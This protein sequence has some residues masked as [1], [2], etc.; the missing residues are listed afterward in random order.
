MRMIIVVMVGMLTWGIVPVSRVLAQGKPKLDLKGKWNLVDRKTNETIATIRLTPDPQPARAGIEEGRY[1]SMTRW[2]RAYNEGRGPS[3]TRFDFDDRELR[4]IY[5]HSGTNRVD[6]LL[7][8]RYVDAIDE[9]N[10]V[11]RVTGGAQIAQNAKGV[12]L[13]FRR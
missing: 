12:E 3:G 10:F 1:E 5:P 11:F 4:I 8:L 6:E 13:I 9:H 7:T 2:P